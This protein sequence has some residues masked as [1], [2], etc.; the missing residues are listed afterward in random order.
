M[1]LVTEAA[2][3]TNTIGAHAHPVLEEGNLSFPRGRYVIDFVDG[4]D[5]PSFEL[6]P[7]LRAPGL[8]S[9]T[10]ERG[11]RLDTGVSYLRHGRFTGGHIFRWGLDSELLG[12]NGS[13]ES[14]LCF[15][16]WYSVR[17]QRP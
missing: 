9:G 8:I 11:E 16:R 1:E 6:I 3:S 7:G 2:A 12:M 15:A 17:A 14:L 4:G 5:G 13:W 10:L